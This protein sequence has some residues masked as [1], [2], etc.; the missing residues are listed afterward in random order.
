MSLFEKK[1]KKEILENLLEKD[2]QQFK[3]TGK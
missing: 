2:Q 1:I 3:T